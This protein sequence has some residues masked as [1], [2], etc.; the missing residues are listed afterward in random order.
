MY[1]VP[2]GFCLP[3]A[4]SGG[5]F[6]LFLA[7]LGYRAQRRPVQTGD[8]GMIGLTGVI[9]GRQGFRDRWIAEVRGEL[10]WCESAMKLQ[11][12]MTVKV[13]GAGDLVLHVVPTCE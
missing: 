8:S 5:A 13:T 10:W 1:S 7:W 9:S 12:G 4:I 2:D 6:A 3:A 11:P